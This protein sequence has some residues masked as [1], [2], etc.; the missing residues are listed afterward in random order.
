M[1]K[2]F[3]WLPAIR[4]IVHYWTRDILFP[5]QVTTEWWNC[6]NLCQADQADDWQPRCRFNTKT[7]QS[8]SWR[9]THMDKG[10]SPQ[11]YRVTS[12]V[13]DTTLFF[14]NLLLRMHLYAISLPNPFTVLCYMCTHNNIPDCVPLSIL[15]QTLVK[16]NLSYHRPGEALRVTRC[17]G[18][19]HF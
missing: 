10:F 15:C 7:K 1:T 8:N 5:W 13:C 9:I 12:A 4:F 6:T 18:S 3:I 11:G 17:S 2:H 19:Q 14:K 16:V